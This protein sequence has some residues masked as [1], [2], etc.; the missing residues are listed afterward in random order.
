MWPLLTVILLCAVLCQS[1]PTLCNPMDCSPPGSSV[2]GDS[3]GKSTG[4]GCHA[5]LQGIFPSQGSNPGL[6]HCRQIFYHLS[7]Q[8][9]PRIPKWVT[10]LFQGI[11]PTR[12]QTAVSCI[13]GRYFTSW[14]TREAQYCPKEHNLLR[15]DV[16][17]RGEHSVTRCLV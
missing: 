13:A 1:C 8:G 16:P 11:F 4:V 12:N 17:S 2:H 14:A 9:S 10:Y 6:P 7:Q 3:P 5:L 15:G